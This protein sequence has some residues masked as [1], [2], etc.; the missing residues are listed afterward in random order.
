MT[1]DQKNWLRDYVKG[2]PRY[3]AEAV[4]TALDSLDA[5]ERERDQLKQWVADLH[6]GMYINCVYCGHRYG[7]AD[8]TPASKADMLKAHIE[9]CPEHPMSRLKT[10]RDALKAAAERHIAEATETKLKL[11]AERDAMEKERDRLRADL[12]AARKKLGEI[13]Q[14]R[15][16]AQGRLAEANVKLGEI[17]EWLR[18]PHRIVTPPVEYMLSRFFP[19]VKP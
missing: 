19:E 16:V 15:Y 17:E 5:M 3:F 18:D 6:S 9:V 12:S 10:E 11:L 4:N 7:P 14:Q 8:K 2:G 1:K 13:E